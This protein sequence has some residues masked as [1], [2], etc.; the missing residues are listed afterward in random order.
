MITAEI[1]RAR[2]LARQNQLLCAICMYVGTATGIA[3]PAV[4][5]IGGTATCLECL[6]EYPVHDDNVT[7]HLIARKD[8]DLT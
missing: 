8:R 4:S 2:R 1:I 5:I 7:A 3:R 6:D